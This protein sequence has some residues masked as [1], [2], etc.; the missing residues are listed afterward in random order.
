MAVLDTDRS[1]LRVLGSVPQVDGATA[2]CGWT[3]GYLICRT[4]K[5]AV[6]VWRISVPG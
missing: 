6:Q 3:V 5:D 1:V 2:G 4:V